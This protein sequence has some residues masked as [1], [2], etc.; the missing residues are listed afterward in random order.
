MTFRT[1]FLPLV[2]A[3]EAENSGPLMHT[4]YIG[5]EVS[6]GVENVVQPRNLAVYQG[7]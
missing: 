2:Q 3:R 5:G 1:G 4:S 7:D 6:T